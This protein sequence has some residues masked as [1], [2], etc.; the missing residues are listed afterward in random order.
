MQH[1]ESDFEATIGKAFPK[2]KLPNKAFTASLEE[3]VFARYRTSLI[4]HVAPTSGF[5]SWVNSMYKRQQGILA[6]GMAFL[7]VLGGYGYFG[8]STSSLSPTIV[9][10]VPLEHVTIEQQPVME[11]EHSVEQPKEEMPREAIALQK[12]PT[13]K[14]PQKKVERDQATP[15]VIAAIDN[16]NTTCETLI[17]TDIQ[18]SPTPSPTSITKIIPTPTN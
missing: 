15:P 14:P 1:N 17:S 5:F 12:Q 7:L 10:S 6:I 13:P 3:K 11:S 9:A 18:K 8:A 4:P 2:R 16:G